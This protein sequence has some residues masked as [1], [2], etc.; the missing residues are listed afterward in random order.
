MSWKSLVL[1]VFLAGVSSLA[2]H[3]VVA[4]AKNPFQAIVKRNVFRLEPIPPVVKPRPALPT[5]KLVGITTILGDKRAILRVQ[6]PANYGETMKEQS[7]ILIEGH[8][9]SA[10]T[11][12]E[13]D[14]IAGTV[15]LNNSGAMM[16]LSLEPEA[17]TVS[18]RALFLH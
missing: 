5:I 14:E 7:L 2:T 1:I 12:M 3:A 17:R 8:S 18:A 11:V 9:E 10:I 16:L 13:I 6:H 15:R 4:S